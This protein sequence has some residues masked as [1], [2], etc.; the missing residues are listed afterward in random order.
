MTSVVNRGDK[1][2]YLATHFAKKIKVLAYTHFMGTAENREQIVIVD[3]ESQLARVIAARYGEIGV[4]TEVI[5]HDEVTP[6]DLERFGNPEITR[7]FWLGGGKHDVNEPGAPTIPE[8]ILEINERLGTPIMASC[9][10]A[11]ALAKALGGEV[12]TADKTELGRTKVTILGGTFSPNGDSGETVEDKLMSHRQVVKEV[13]EG[14]V[15]TAVSP[16]GTAGYEIKDRKIYADQA[17]VESPQ[18][19]RGKHYFEKYAEICGIVPSE[20]AAETYIADILEMGD[21]ELIERAKEGFLQIF[22]SGGVDSSVCAMRAYLALKEVGLLHR[23]VFTYVDTGMMRNNDLAAVQELISHGIPIEIVDES[24]LFIHTA[25]ELTPEE[26]KREKLTNPVLPT[27][28]DAP[29][30]HTVRLINRYGF[31][32]VHQKQAQKLR[33]I[34]GPDTKVILVMG[35][36]AADIAESDAEIK[37]HHNQGIEES[38]DGVELP[39]RYFF[40]GQIRKAGK[41]AG[42]SKKLHGRQPFPGPAESLRV[43]PSEEAYRLGTEAF[44]EANQLLQDYGKNS[45]QDFKYTLTPDRTRAVRGDEGSN[46]YS[47]VLEPKNG[48]IPW[49]EMPE[50]SREI[51]NTIH[52]IARIGLAPLGFEAGAPHHHVGLKRTPEMFELARQLES[53]K[54]SWLDG[55]GFEDEL[56]Q[57][58]MALTDSSLTHGLKDPTTWLRLF[59]S[60]GWGKSNEDMMT[61]I[62]P[63]PGVD[64]FKDYDTALKMLATGMMQRFKIGGFILDT[65]EKPFG[66]VER[67]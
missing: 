44:E 6:A 67:I 64:G 41:D 32:R 57:H 8:G 29:D 65:T 13:P 50:I 33:D 7:G 24:E 36:N 22:V 18:T 2:V 61:G 62:V 48:N 9:Y 58:F 59:Q 46:G 12:V 47:V 16:A 49:S 23:A 15:V 55:L 53:Y 14:A 5:R 45:L 20:E 52:Q 51:G 38:V 42:L 4:R 21:T 25:I 27:M 28:I 40:K 11:Q 66:T 63:F 56:S 3:F 39:L 31:V 34:H 10:G 30:A 43:V 19:T 26:A 1:V 37:A 35:T 60:G 54:D 17:H